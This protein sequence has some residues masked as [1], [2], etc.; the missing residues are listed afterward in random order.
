MK[1]RTLLAALLPALLVAPLGPGLP[2]AA[3]DDVVRRVPGRVLDVADLRT[4][5]PP[6]IAW[7]ERRRGRTTIHDGSRATPL[8]AEVQAFAPMGTGYVVQ[9]TD[10]DRPGA[11]PLVRWVGADGSPGRRT[12]R[13][14]YGLAVSAHDG[15]VAFTVRR[16]GVRVIDSDGDRVLRMP[17]VPDRG[18]ASPAGVVGE[19]CREDATSNGCAVLVNSNRRPLSWVVSSH[20]I[21]DTTGLRHVSTARGRWLGG[22]T[23]L[24]DGGSCSRMTRSWRTRWRTCRNQLSGIAPGNRHLIGTPAYADGFGP[25]SLDVL[26]LRT[27]EPVRAWRAARDGSSATYFEEVWED[28]EHVLVVTFQDREWAVVRLGLDGSM[29]YAV[30]PRRGTDLRRPFHLR[31]R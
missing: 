13:S 14:G 20:G 1:P 8:D 22:I 23:R 3:G 29:E 4:G 21:V 31:T 19:D 28:A 25:T 30:P 10:P 24:F 18:F 2:A 6:A 5:A 27:G 11:R 12:W 17:S 16:G 26:D 7:A 9:L 15:A